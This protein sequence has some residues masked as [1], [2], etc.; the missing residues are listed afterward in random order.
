MKMTAER[1]HGLYASGIP[2][3]VRK[4]YL[5]NIAEGMRA[6]RTGNIKPFEGF[7]PNQEKG[8][9]V[10]GMVLDD[11]ALQERVVGPFEA[12]AQENGIEIYSANLGWPHIT[13]AQ[14]IPE[15]NASE[16]SVTTFL[17]RMKET[18]FIGSQEEL[19]FDTLWGGR[20]I[21]LASTQIPPTIDAIR[22]AM[23][24][25]ASACGMENVDYSNI[26]HITVGRVGEPLPLAVSNEFGKLCM[27]I[28]KELVRDPLRVPVR[29]HLMPNGLY[30]DVHDPGLFAAVA[31]RARKLK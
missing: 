15:E 23:A 14:A 6:A 21:T 10:R 5:T 13:V 27:K 9:S 28:Q 17:E 2:E 26:A 20:D 18:Q 7:A 1:F 30:N 3:G 8:F 11:T 31:Q 16:K 19:T 4:K 24:E 25:K 22:Q 29:Y 12:F